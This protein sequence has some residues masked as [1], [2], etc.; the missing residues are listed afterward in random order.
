MRKNVIILCISKL[1][2][3]IYKVLE[4]KV[5]FFVP[6]GLHF[7]G[8]LPN[9]KIAGFCSYFLLGFHPPTPTPRRIFATFTLARAEH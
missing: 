1:E 7:I 4:E 8:K 9:V 2:Q 6:E 5:T 3:F